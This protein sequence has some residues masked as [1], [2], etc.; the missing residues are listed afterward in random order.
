M[1]LPAFLVATDPAPVGAVE[2][3]TV[4]SLLEPV[5]AGCEA[6]LGFP[7][8]VAAA[9]LRDPGG[10]PSPELLAAIAGAHRDGARHLFVVP[11]ALGLDVRAREHLAESARAARRQLGDLQIAYGDPDPCHPLVVQALVDRCC[12][13]LAASGLRPDRL[14]VLLVA[15]GDGDPDSRARSYQL[16]R[17]LWEHL[18]TARG[19]VAFLR[20]AR[21]PLPEQL[22]ACQRDG[23]PWVIVPQYLW[24][25]DHLAYLRV[26]VDD[27][28]KRCPEAATWPIAAPLGAHRNVARWLEEQAGRLWDQAQRQRRARRPSPK[29]DRATGI[30]QYGDGLI[31]SV[32]DRAD[33]R[34]LV[35]EI[36]IAADPVVV[37]VT[38]HGYA[39]GTYT[40][41]SAL[42]ALLAALPG[43]A[44]LVEG[45]SAS[46][47]RGGA[48][49]DWEQ[50]A[51]RHRDWI[52]AEE[53]EYLRRTG[54]QEV[55]DRH[56]ARYLNVT[57]A[58]WDGACADPADVEA[59]LA[60]RGVRLGHRELLGLVPAEL[61]ALAGAPFLS[62]ARF[63][64]PTRL[65][66]ANLFGLLPQPLRTA[67]HGPNI[68]FFAR[69]C[70]DLA[71]LYGTLFEPFG[72]VEG[73]DAA[74]RWE[75]DGLYRS[76]WGNYDLVTRPDL[77]CLSRGL[78]TADVLASRLQGQDVRRSAFFDVV[79]SE[80]GFADE[81][82]T[83]PIA[84]ALRL[85]L[86]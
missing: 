85:R 31:A 71:R 64:G 69:V 4:A 23:R 58:W 43:K 77:L 15:P 45:H 35:R 40:D 86:A 63:K 6:R 70:C 81:L 27:F 82:A 10:A 59:R 47:H 38:W 19:E 7:A 66:I 48:D 5:R 24:H 29:R 75:R 39:P 62:F 67:W 52:R 20:H 60:A 8:R 65:S 28:A 56:R 55:I 21:T 9:A 61:V 22:A 3:A 32:G 13:A 1:S 36:G 26:I 44:I 11:A 41:P 46:R 17:L 2:L 74:V 84:E 50:D 83:A 54:L 42:D 57:E 72:A 53:Q 76:R 14:G 12:E 33:L 51:V 79:R 25:A 16:M 68:T 73:L 49:W 80:L 37:K 30:W 18:G 78:P 34:G